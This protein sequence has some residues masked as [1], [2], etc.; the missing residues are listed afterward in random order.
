MRKY[1]SNIKGALSVL[2]K[3]TPKRYFFV[4]LFSVLLEN[5]K[6]LLSIIIPAIIVDTIIYDKSL[7]SIFII[8]LFYAGVTV[9]TDII[10]KTI[11]LYITSYWYRAANLA[12]FD[13]CQKWMKLGY[14][15][16]DSPSV[17]DQYSQ[18]IKSPWEF[19]CL[20]DLI[21]V[22]L[23]GA[24]LIIVE[25][26]IILFQ[27]HILVMLGVFM[28]S[29][30]AAYIRWKH[31]KVAHE[32][33]KEVTSLQR[34]SAYPVRLMHDYSYGK[35]VRL[36]NMLPLLS[37]LYRRV[38][39]KAVSMEIMSA[40]RSA[41]VN[42]VLQL[43]DASK[44]LL[45]Y[46]AA[47]FRYI[48]GA[49]TLGS[50]T[51][52]LNSL[53]ALS[54]ALGSLF[55]VVADIRNC[56][57]HFDDYRDFLSIKESTTNESNKVSNGDISFKNVSF[58]YPGSVNYIFIS[59]SFDIK[60]GEHIAIVGENGAGKTTLIKLLTGLYY[61]IEGSVT[62]AG[63][64]S[65]SVEKDS[66]YSLFSTVFQDF[67]L[68]SVPVAENIAFLKRNDTENIWRCLGKCQVEGVVSNLKYAL[69]TNVSKLLDE[70]GVDF[71]GGERQKI[72]LTR[73]FYKDAPI[74]ILDEPT[75]AL[76]PIAE[77]EIF[78]LV[79]NVS[80]GKTVFYISHRISTTRYADKIMVIGDRG[81][82]EFG[83][84]KELMEKKG[85]FYNLFKMQSEPYVG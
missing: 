26:I 61:P 63:I 46:I 1:V 52:Y 75:A 21:F 13:V 4:M 51:M 45:V 83:T 35:E 41:K 14:E 78:S 2:Y 50:F 72:A 22:R 79:R 25:M 54:D 9:L 55:T 47:V 18:A 44:M 39:R 20:D 30:L 11:S 17:L 67:E 85:R 49:L 16:L 73:A 58:H 31:M 15:Y 43:V 6:Q 40:S 84:F 62:I 33:S 29:I 7:K 38:N 80:S 12:T 68:Y 8:S 66:Y 81:V 28:L 32:E 42:T 34:R 74:L 70:D 3:H 27:I 56:S 59:V 64:D 48:R 23:L 5:V 71:S 10:K 24:I 53:T 65:R 57:L 77:N 37:T 60:K 19:L 76:D 69:D 82:L 36:Y